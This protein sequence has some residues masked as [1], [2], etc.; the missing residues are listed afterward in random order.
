MAP[1]WKA[2]DHLGREYS[3]ADFQER[4]VIVIFFLGFGCV[5][6]VEQLLEFSPHTR[7]FAAAGIDLVAIG[8]DSIEQ[9]SESQSG[10][11]LESGYPFP[12][13]SDASLELFKRYRAYDDFEDLPLH[14]T[15]LVDTKGRMRWEDISYEPFMDWEFLLTE[16]QRLLGL[17]EAGE[18]GD[19]LSKAPN[20]SGSAG[21]GGR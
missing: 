8:T 11:T 21:T 2:P 5:H 17:P 15:F 20:H 7:E 14:G 19:P 4:P 3:M 12:I 10:D 9:L 18:P 6:C 16:S 13:L 1:D